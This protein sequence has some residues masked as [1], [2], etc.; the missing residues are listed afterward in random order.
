MASGMRLLRCLPALLICL[1]A[2]CSILQPEPPPTP[3]FWQPPTVENEP[4]TFTP[5]PQA[6]LV[7]PPAIETGAV[8]LPTLPAITATPAATRI[9]AWR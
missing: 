9:P 8:V 2:G 6:S 4:A 1:A 3:G 7:S 5:S